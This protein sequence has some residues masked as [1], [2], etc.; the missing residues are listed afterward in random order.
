MTTLRNARILEL[1]AGGMAMKAIAAEMG[2]KIFTVERLVY[3]NP[4]RRKWSS[5]EWTAEQD[6]TIRQMCAE[7][8]TWQAIAS[9]LDIPRNTVIA[10]ARGTLECSPIERQAASKEEAA[11]QRAETRA[12]RAQEPLRAGHDATWKLISSEPWPR[13][14]D[15]WATR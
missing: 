10:H 11:V 8:A 7:G 5:R 1:R 6:A 4:S 9:A 2:V 13:A 14:S 15:V 12:V 3:S